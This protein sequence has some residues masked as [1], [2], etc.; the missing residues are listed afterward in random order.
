MCNR[1]VPNKKT[2]AASL[3]LFG[4]TIMSAA[5]YFV[6]SWFPS[7][8]ELMYNKVWLITSTS[9]LPSLLMTPTMTMV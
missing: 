9:H 8:E 6:G 7:L 1:S 4:S 2:M 3:A 5:R